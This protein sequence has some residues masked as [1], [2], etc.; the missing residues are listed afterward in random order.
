M[1]HIRRE[2]ASDP[3]EV[4]LI[5]DLCAAAFDDPAYRDLPA[6][7]RAVDGYRPHWCL[8]AVADGEIVGHVMA[9]LAELV[10]GK[11]RTAIPSLS[12]LAV[13]PDRQRGGIGSALVE[14]VVAEVERAGH[15]KVV[16]E[17][18]PDYYQRLGFEPA[19]D[20]GIVMPLPDWAPAEAGQIR[21]LAGF[22]PTPGRVVYPP[23]TQSAFS[24]VE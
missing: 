17:G 15:S 2:D 3:T 21:R 23:D 7:L 11:D 13:R 9:G 22:A 1:H 19:R 5:G 6:A 20:H 4:A 18:S 16:L 24:S 12:P 10:T 14:H 8:V